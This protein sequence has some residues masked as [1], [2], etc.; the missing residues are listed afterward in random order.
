MDGGSRRRNGP[1]V[2][3]VSLR[4]RVRVSETLGRTTP[5]P[6]SGVPGP[7]DTG[8][9]TGKDRPRDRW[10]VRTRG[11][12][13]RN[14]SL[15][16]G[17]TRRAQPCR[18]DYSFPV[19]LP[20]GTVEHPTRDG[21]SRDSGTTVRMTE[22]VIPPVQGPSVGLATDNTDQR[23]SLTVIPE[24]SSSRSRRT[25]P[26]PSTRLRSCPVGPTPSTR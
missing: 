20:D 3:P 9:P 5:V 13:G 6:S 1:Q 14:R 24:S 15:G 11:R 22:S 16:G 8:P 23:V 10:D 21:G 17:R 18:T 4:C 12:A 19:L 7:G 26:T 25:S 2:F